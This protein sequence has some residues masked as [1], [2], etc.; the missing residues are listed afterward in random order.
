FSEQR[1]QTRGVVAEGGGTLENFEIFALDYDADRHYFLSQYF[2]NKYDDALKNYPLIDSRVQITRIEVWVTNR[3]N[4]I[5]ASPNDGF[6]NRNIIALQDLGE[7][8]IQGLT[9]NQVVVLLQNHLN[10]FFNM[11]AN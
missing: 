5:N 6:N 9:D 2:R 10:G 8:Q 11:P 1:S 4:R 3:Q 7:A